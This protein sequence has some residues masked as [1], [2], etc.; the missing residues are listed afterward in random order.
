[1]LLCAL[2]ERLHLHNAKIR[3]LMQG[4]KRLVRSLRTGYSGERENDKVNTS[5]FCRLS[6]SMQSTEL[7]HF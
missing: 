1:M 5:S 4:L 2:R 3:H 6:E 7:V